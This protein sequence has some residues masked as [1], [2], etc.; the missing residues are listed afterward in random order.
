M[1]PQRP[2]PLVKM[3]TKAAKGSPAVVSMV[4]YS[5]AM[6]VGISGKQYYVLIECT[7]TG[8]TLDEFEMLD[9]D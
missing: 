7:L 1:Y 5:E 9:I 6:S 8:D 2:K 3:T 4:L